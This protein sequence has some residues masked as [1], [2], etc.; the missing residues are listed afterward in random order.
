[1]ASG[2]TSLLTPG[3]PAL[4]PGS[5]QITVSW[6]AVTGATSYEIWYGINNISA[7]AQKFTGTIADNNCIITGLLSG[8]TYYV[9]IKAKNDKETSNFGS[10]SYCATL[11]DAPNMPALVPGINQLSVSWNSVMSATSY[12][13]WYSSS[14][15]Y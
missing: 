14:S 2:A 12:E 6:D 7:L 4:T 9:W 1:M 3:A 8:T 13:V 5:N 10:V 11:L 15:N